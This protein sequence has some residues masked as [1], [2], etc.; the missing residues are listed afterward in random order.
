MLSESDKEFI[1]T[2]HEKDIDWLVEQT[3][4]SKK[5]IEAYLS[6]YV[7]K[8]ALANRVRNQVSSKKGTAIMTGTVSNITDEIKKN[9]TNTDA[10]HIHKI[11]PE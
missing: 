9:R 7:K 6:G 3:K 11:R 10:E 1:Q 4:R 8:N 2:N 5:D